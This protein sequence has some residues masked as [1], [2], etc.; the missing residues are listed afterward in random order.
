MVSPSVAIGSGVA[1]GD[2]RSLRARW[3]CGLR[4]GAGPFLKLFLC[5]IEFGHRF[6]PRAPVRGPSGK[7]ASVRDGEGPAALAPRGP[8]G[9]SLLLAAAQADKDSCFSYTELSLW[10]KEG[11]V[12][13]AARPRAGCDVGDVPSLE[14]GM[15][16]FGSR[17]LYLGARSLPRYEIDDFFSLLFR[18]LSVLPVEAPGAGGGVI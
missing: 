8:R 16:A 10:D 6:S 2:L 4:R 7:R 11:I 5:E 12:E 1:S 3:R 15:W 17:R 13:I 9:R 14:K 18:D